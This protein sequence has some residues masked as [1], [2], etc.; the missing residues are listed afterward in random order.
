M[1]S[2]SYSLANNIIWIFRKILHLAILLPLTIILTIIFIT[3]LVLSAVIA[4]FAKLWY[5]V[6]Q[7]KE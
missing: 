4:S 5:F 1:Q 2:V 3:A 7:N 6:M